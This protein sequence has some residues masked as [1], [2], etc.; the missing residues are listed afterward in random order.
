ML[1]AL[2]RKEKRPVKGE[3]QVPERVRQPDAVLLRWPST[4]LVSLH[5]QMCVCVRERAHVSVHAVDEGGRGQDGL[6]SGGG[7]S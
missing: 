4:C 3:D 1:T 7:K 6:S 2:V 5:L